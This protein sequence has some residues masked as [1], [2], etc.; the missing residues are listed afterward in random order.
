MSLANLILNFCLYYIINIY[1]VAIFLETLEEIANLDWLGGSTLI[2]QQKRKEKWE[3]Y[4]K[5]NIEK[6]KKVRM[7]KI[8]NKWW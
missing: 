4:I 5:G 3:K 1:F 8:I 7:I 2:N 6:E